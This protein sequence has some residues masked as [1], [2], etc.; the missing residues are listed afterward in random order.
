MEQISSKHKIYI[1]ESEGCTYVGKLIENKDG[2][3]TLI[4]AVK[5]GTPMPVSNEKGEV[6]QLLVGIYIGKLLE[7]PDE[8]YISELEEK[9]PYFTEYYKNASNLT[10]VPPGTAARNLKIT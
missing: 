8:V 3:T 6:L 9:S 10:L 2:T 5:F 1:I 4:D 7:Y